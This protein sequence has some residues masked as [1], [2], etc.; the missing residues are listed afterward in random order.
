MKT[1]ILAILA[2]GALGLSGA[3]AQARCPRRRFS[4]RRV[5]RRRSGLSSWPAAQAR[6]IAGVSEYQYAEPG[7]G[8]GPRLHYDDLG[9]Y[10]F[11][12]LRGSQSGAARQHPRLLGAISATGATRAAISKVE[13]SS[14]ETVRGTAYPSTTTRA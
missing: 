9:Q 12:R 11:A 7:Y 13:P 8:Y 2:F 5:V 4:K 10:L 14:E 1:K 3:T 6:A